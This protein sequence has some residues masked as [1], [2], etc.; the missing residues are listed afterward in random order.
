MHNKR[1]TKS[2][3]LQGTRDFNVENPC[4]TQGKNHGRQP[5]KLHYFGGV[6]KRR[7][8]TM[9]RRNPSG[10]LQGKYI[11]GG[12]DPYRRRP[13]PTG[14]GPRSARQ[15]LASSWNLDH[16][17]TNSTLRQIPCSMNFNN[18]LNQQR[19]HLLAPIATWAKQLYQPSLSKAQTW[20][21]GQA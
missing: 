18:H 12:N 15:K 13:K 3:T 7:G 20:T 11:D 19:K 14:D 2:K 8:C 21:Q 4:N 9:M 10:G 17:I 6:Y 5:A 1:R 16:N